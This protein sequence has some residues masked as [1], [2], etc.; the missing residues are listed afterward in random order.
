MSRIIWGRKRAMN[1]H[2]TLAKTLAALALCGL[3][4]ALPALALAQAEPATA[5][6]QPAPVGVATLVLLL[7]MGAVVMVGGAMIA[8]D[9]FT[10]DAD[11]NP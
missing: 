8:R 4:L 6:E 11:E 9:S 3:L 1:T 5:E 7:G 2:T 10:G